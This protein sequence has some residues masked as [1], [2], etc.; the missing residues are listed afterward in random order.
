M[1]AEPHLSANGVEPRWRIWLRSLTFRVVALSSIWAII[2]LVIISTVIV[3]LFRQA[4]ERGFEGVLSAHLFNLIGS[5][6][7]EDDESQ[8]S[9][10]PN[11]GDLRFARPGSG[12]YW[13]V[14]PVSKGM[15]EPVRSLSMT[16]S[17]PSPPSS[18]V[19]FNSDFQRSYEV[20]DSSGQML[21]VLESELVLGQGDKVARFRVMGNRTELEA[22]IAQFARRLYS[23]LAIFGISMIVINVGAIIYGLRPLGLVRRAL[24]DIRAGG[25]QQLE[26]PFPPEI[27]PLAHETNALIASNRRV[28][29]RSRTQ[30]GNLAHSLKTPLAVLMNESRAIGGEKGDLIANQA[31]GMRRQV[32]HYLQRARVAAQRDNLAFR[33]PVNAPLRRMARALEKLNPGTRI[34][35]DIPDEEIIFAGEQGDLEEIVGNLLENAMKW[36]HASVAM[37]LARVAEKDAWRTMFEIVIEDDGPGI[38]EDKAREAV[39]RGRRLDESKPGTGLGLSIVADLAD[40][41]GGYLTLGRSRLGGLKAVV[42]LSSGRQ[43]GAHPD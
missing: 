28:L 15:G 27:A 38:P 4:S 9:G 19:P 3:A 22:E 11:L 2:A 40:D 21:E 16:E 12:W 17:V 36:T 1:P 8:I 26:G 39:K 14:E 25:A 34:G 31:A 7:I 42:R 6:G 35:L 5:V 18:Q 13:S 41:Y 33:T 30:V 23:Y 43:S 32:D 20:K 10:S 37:S 24:A 29:E